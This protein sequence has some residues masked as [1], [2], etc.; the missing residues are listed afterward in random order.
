MIDQAISRIHRMTQNKQTFIHTVVI[1][2]TVEE[3]LMDNVLRKKVVG[4]L[5]SLCWQVN[6]NLIY[7]RASY[8][9]QWW[10]IMRMMLA[11]SRRELVMIQ[12]LLWSTWKIKLCHSIIL[13]VILP[14]FPPTLFHIPPTR[15]FIL[16]QHTAGQHHVECINFR[17]YIV[18]IIYPLPDFS[19]ASYSI[20]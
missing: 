1:K 2:D 4:A 15:P 9:D 8:L 13:V 17:C 7:N 12:T 10:Q 6:I 16:F 11:T 18:F 14:L 3:G 19:V 5:H 20:R